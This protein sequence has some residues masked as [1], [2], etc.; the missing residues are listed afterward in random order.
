M[1]AA[2]ITESMSRCGGGAER[3]LA[4]ITDY[5]ANLGWEISLLSFNDGV[6]QSFY[7]LN[8]KVRWVRIA[9]QNPS[10][11]RQIP[12]EFLRRVFLLREE[13]KTLSPDIV[14]SFMN[15]TNLFSFLAARSLSIPIIISDRNNPEKKAL[16]LRWKLLQEFLYPKAQKLVIL[17]PEQTRC[18]SPSI[19]KIIEPISIAL[20]LPPEETLPHEQTFKKPFIL[21][22]GRFHPQ[23][24]FDLLI[25]AFHAL[26]DSHPD[27]NLVILGDGDQRTFLEKQIQEKGLKERIFLPGYKYNPYAM[28]KASDIFVFPS[29]YEGFGNAFLEAMALGCPVLASDCDFGPKSVIRHDDNGFL[30]KNENLE[31]LIQKLKHLMEDE[32][33]RKRL[34]QNAPEV[35]ELYSLSRVLEKWK[36]LI[37]SLV[38]PQAAEKSL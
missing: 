35:K 26:A 36:R 24:G 29:R 11:Y 12:G 14:I 8:P 17:T 7:P 21:A 30:F 32:S 38:L 15:V 18:Y 20:N 31:D 27:W 10:R 2:F 13:F 22:A 4:R 1:R 33:L 16:P 25:Q 19:Q 23:K 34:A 5:F 28:M 3:E 6:P 9:S 37:Q